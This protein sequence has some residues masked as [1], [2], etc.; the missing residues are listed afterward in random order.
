M[1]NYVGNHGQTNILNVK[2]KNSILT[3]RGEDMIFLVKGE[4]LISHQYLYNKLIYP[5]DDTIHPLNNWGQ[6]SNKEQC[7]VHKV[8]TH[9]EYLI[10]NDSK[11]P[12]ATQKIR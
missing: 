3:A 9:G 11:G 2:D 10:E 5:M 7:T 6:V 1:G 8:R 12:P 4:T